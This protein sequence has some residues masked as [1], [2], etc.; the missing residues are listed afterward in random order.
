LPARTVGG[1]YFDFI[2][3]NESE[4][5][6]IIADVSGKGMPAALLMANLQAAIRTV[7]P[8][9]LPLSSILQNINKL[10][11]RNTGSDKFVTLFLAKINNIENSF[12]YIN[13]GHNPP[14]LFTSKLEKKELIEGGIVLGILPEVPKFGFEKMTLNT[15][16]K[17]L[18]YTDGISEAMNSQKH[19]FG[20]DRIDNFII[21]DKS[22]TAKNFAE[23]LLIELNSF[24]GNAVQHDDITLITIIKK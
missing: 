22:M 18:L 3:I 12:E 19:E 4:H 6:I 1:D 17:I 10:L 2:K 13:A 14:I 21:S 20:C 23:N 5:I 15:G 7:A 11:Y 16:D 8:L 24:V 9:N